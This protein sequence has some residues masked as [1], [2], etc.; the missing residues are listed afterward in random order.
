MSVYDPIIVSHEVRPPLADFELTVPGDLYYLRG[1]FP[2]A[3]IV[4]GVVQIHWAIL[5]ANRCLTL[6]PRFLGVESLKFH[7][8]ITPVAT[9]S[10]TL[11]YANESAKL[12]FCYS[13]KDGRHSQ[14]R[15]LFG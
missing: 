9:L 15:I 12:T 8:V 14:G 5:L 1:H 7:R 2:E 10:L 11:S 3:P 4:P 13:S 6:E